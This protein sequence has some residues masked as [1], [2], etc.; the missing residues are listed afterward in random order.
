MTKT[1]FKQGIF[2][3]MLVG[4]FFFILKNRSDAQANLAVATPV[5]G[6]KVINTYKHDKNAFTQGLLYVDDV[7]YE[8]T[9]VRGRSSIR[10]VKLETGEVLK[11]SNLPN[12]LFGE[13]LALWKNQF[14]QLSWQAGV[15][16]VYE[17]ESF[18]LSR[19]FRYKGEGW[20]LTTNK[21]SFIMSDGTADIRFLDPETFSEVKRITVTDA[22][23]EIKMLNELEFINGE[24]YA[25]VWLTNKIVRIDP[26]SGKVIAWID[27]SSLVPKGYEN[28]QD[29]VLN[30]IAYDAT[31]KRL[32]VTGK[33]WPKL[34][35]VEVV[36][37]K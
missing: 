21:D 18:K 30:G 25:N 35:E 27:L 34:F 14:V 23:K 12:S 7:L 36:E 16:L 28:N 11:K 9:G 2:I 8:S 10:K 17:K 4:F 3:C 29:A 15:A 5:Q 33:L 1:Q 13:G 20:G 19:V 26:K 6:V 31:K 32:F 37:V 22:G 24:I